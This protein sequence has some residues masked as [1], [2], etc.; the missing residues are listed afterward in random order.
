MYHTSCSP[1]L[2]STTLIITGDDEY[3]SRTAYVAHSA[4]EGRMTFISKEEG[5]REII[6]DLTTGDHLAD[7][8]VHYF[9]LRKSLGI[10]VK[11][12]TFVLQGETAV[13]EEV[14]TELESLGCLV[15]E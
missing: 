8:I 4:L 1:A 14:K 12:K 3:K 7:A 2:T 9:K 10:P 15:R 11:N 13:K 6:I 5:I